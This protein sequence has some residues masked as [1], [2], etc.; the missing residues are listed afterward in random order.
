MDGLVNANDK[1]AMGQFIGPAGRSGSH[2]VQSLVRMQSFVIRIYPPVWRGHEPGGGLAQ[3]RPYTSS[4]SLFLAP[5]AD[6]RER[7]AK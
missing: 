4:H 5:G 6:T 3:R 1:L 2:D 7:T